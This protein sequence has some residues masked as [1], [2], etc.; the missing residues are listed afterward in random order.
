MSSSSPSTQG[1]RTAVGPERRGRMLLCF[2]FEGAYG[3]PYD[4]P[5]DVARGAERILAVLASHRARA[6]FFVVGRMAEE[7]PDV[8][9]T[10]A[11]AGHEIGLHGYDHDDLSAYN[12]GQ[13]T[14]LDSDLARVESLMAELTGSPPRFFRAP[15]LLSPRFYR[16][17]IYELLASH[18]YRW[19]SNQEVRYPVELLRPDRIPFHHVWDRGPSAPPRLA[20]S[21]IWLAALN[22]GLILGGKFGTSPAS[23]LR[24]L[25]STRPPFL[26]DGLV[27]IPVYAPLDCDLLGLPR[28]AEETP[29]DL[30]AYTRATLR[31]LVVN[32]GAP[33]AMVTFHDWIV[34]GGNR[35][36][37][38]DEVLRAASERNV[39]VIT[40]AGHLPLLD[41]TAAAT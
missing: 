34:A 13:L 36:V 8:V 26:R 30:L 29:A 19:V 28:P 9:A 21:R 25:M 41:E 37:L 40:V 18:G 6:T 7:H 22:P 39:D 32:P 23:R 35:L 15:Y 31:S 11:D 5:Y 24:W 14:Q 33:L 10:L 20:S 12:Q 1:M 17:E 38:L 3:M 4:S 27:E 16:R 2:D